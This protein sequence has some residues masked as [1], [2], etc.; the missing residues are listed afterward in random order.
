MKKLL[1]TGLIVFSLSFS[2]AANVYVDQSAPPNGDGTSWATAFNDIQSAVDVAAANDV[3]FLAEG[4][5][6]PQSDI[7]IFIPLTIKGGYPQGGG[8][9]NIPAHIAQIQA[10]FDPNDLFFL[11]FDVS[12][13][14]EFEIEGVRFFQT[15]RAIHTDS[16]IIINKVQFE[17]LTNNGLTIG[18]DIDSVSI[19]NSIFSNSEDTSINNGGRVVADFTLE[20][21][22][23]QN[24][25]TTAIQISDAV[26]NFTMSDCTIK[27]YNSSSTLMGFR[28]NNVLLDNLLAENNTLETSALIGLSTTTLTIRD[29]QI[30]NNIGESAVCFSGS[31]CDVTLEGSSFSN[32]TSNGSFATGVFSSYNSTISATNC[33]FN[34]NDTVGSQPNGVGTSNGAETVLSFDRCEFKNNKADGSIAYGLFKLFTGV[35]LTVTNSIIDGNEGN[36]GCAI[37]MFTLGEMILE[38]NIFRNHNNG[39]P[40]IDT[41]NSTSGVVIINNNIFEENSV[42]DLNITNTASLTSTNNIFN[43]P[44]AFVNISG[45]NTASLYNDYFKGNE[46]D[47]EFLSLNNTNAS[48]TNTVMISEKNSGTHDVIE[49][50]NGVALNILNSTFSSRTLSNINV[51]LDFDDGQPSTIYNSIIWAGNDLTNSGLTGNLSDLTVEYSLIKGEN[52][53][54]IGDLDG[55]LNDNRPW[56]VDQNSLDFRLRACSPAVN[57]GNNSYFTDTLDHLGNPRIFETTIDM[58]AYE[59]Q[60][61]ASATCEEPVIPLCT[62][63]IAPVNNETNVPIDTNL[64]WSAVPDAVQY[65]LVVGTSAGSADILSVFLGN[66]TNYNLANDLPEN[67]QIYVRVTPINGAGANQNCV[68]ESFTTA[69]GDMVS[70][71]GCSI[72]ILPGNGSVNE[73][74]DSDITWSEDTNANGYRLTAGTTSG[75]NDIL[76]NFDVGNVTTYDF[77]SDL[78]ENTEIFIIVV[79]YNAIGS[80]ETCPERSFTTGAAPTIPNCTILNN[81]ND[82]A[83]DVSVATNINWNAIVDADG[84]IITIGTTSGGTDIINNQDVGNITTFDIPTNLP[85][86]TEIFVTIIPYNSAGNAT[87][88]AEES[89]TTESASIDLECTII[90]SP[91]ANAMNVPVNTNIS[92]NAVLGATGYRVNIGTD[93][94][95]W[96]ILDDFDVGNTTTVNPPI[97]LP[98]NTEIFVLITPYD[99]IGTLLSCEEESFG[100]E[101]TETIPNCT[102]L[103]TP[104]NNAIDVSIFTDLTWNAISN[105]E[106]YILTIGTTSGGTDIINN[107]DVGNVT[108]YDIP[109]DLPITTEIF[110]TVT[111]YNALG[112][113]IDCIE[114]S[115]I[116]ELPLPECSNLLMPSF[117]ELDVPVDTDLIWSASQY[118]EG[119]TVNIGTSTGATDILDVTDVG[120]VTTYDIPFDLPGGTVIYIT[121]GSYNSSGG[122]VCGDDQFT[123]EIPFVGCSSLIDPLNGATNVSVTTDITWSA[124]DNADGYILNVGTSPTV[125]D[126]LDGFNVTNG[127]TS[128]DFVNDLPANTEI[129]VKLIT[130]N[131]FSVDET[132]TQ[133]SFTTGAANSMLDCTTLTLPLAGETNVSVSTNFSWNAVEGAN[134]YLIS[135][136]TAANL[137]GG[138]DVGN[139]LTYDLPFDLPE[140]TEIIVQ[141]SPYLTPNDTFG[142]ASEWFTTG[143]A[144][145]VPDCTSLILPV[146]DSVNVP[147]SEDISWNAVANASGYLLNIGT[148]SGGTDIANTIDLGNVTT[149]DIP[150]D[151]P[152]NTVIF[153]TVTP[154][155]LEGNAISCTEDSFTTETL[156]TIPECTYLISPV[157]GSVNVP[158][159]ED[160]SWNTV[161]NASGY[162]LN[163]GTTSGGTDIIN[164]IDLGNVTT[165]DIPVN[166]PENTVI[167]VTVIPYNSEGNA[168][169]CDEESFTT[170]TQIVFPEV[171]ETKYG[172]SPDGN[173]INDFWEIKGIQ[174][175]TDNVVYIY[176]RWGDLVFEI[177]G[178]DNASRVFRGD[179]NKKNRLGAGRLPSGTYFFNIQINGPHNLKKTKGFVVLKR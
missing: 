173:G 120:N 82:G 20:N 79:P 68:D 152:E 24:G 65:Q 13:N 117:Q 41:Y 122:T 61:P 147:I 175:F 34:N 83:I 156:A 153:V 129:F 144:P 119:Y 98:E 62:N 135:V 177:K 11:I 52:L 159:S 81:P 97:D 7:D 28:D 63:L 8:V 103:S 151:L 75:G 101:F 3:I 96:D 160:I 112:N 104:L 55:T 174:N 121:I 143:S 47:A 53:G 123:T 141:I 149:Y 126:I 136:G 161:A 73:E 108:T 1:L 133:E 76:N 6:K 113:A 106:G 142:C 138:D 45:V 95:V 5:Y 132:C 165:Y 111:P 146:D 91:L 116:T 167:F 134:G 170:E 46:N 12:S 15:R 32:N 64:S 85:E 48:I 35:S 155:N 16:N 27:D 58:G 23:F 77:P 4:I 36:N 139:A 99:T 178:Y 150:G 30:I 54:G 109:A 29:S 88:C 71:V 179:A 51:R 110:V 172:F 9:Q 115:F 70:N 118:A 171:E 166:L 19:T 87:S 131:A 2:F 38:N 127:N 128:H 86:N 10:D 90:N 107:M 21:C 78:P 31:N 158:I 39:G 154:Y 162:L 57:A 124:A 80:F 114:E 22:V 49:S 137:L 37:N 145:A 18:S 163:I 84:Y 56:F 140:N 93:S 100:T 43:G 42:P 74:V 176:N 33:S 25:Q 67:T 60:E 125:N 89:F 148:T 50:G 40:V 168:Q 69:I 14:S 105:A 102:S 130:V 169:S 164:T 157:D 92:W 17:G 94:G 59:L 66:V 26:V 72:L 44:S